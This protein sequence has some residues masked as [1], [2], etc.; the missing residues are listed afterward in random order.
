[1]RLT[2][3]CHDQSQETILTPLRHLTGIVFLSQKKSILKID[4][5]VKEAVSQPR[6]QVDHLSIQ[7]RRVGEYSSTFGLKK[8]PVAPP[9]QQIFL[10]PRFWVVTW[11][12]ASR[13]SVP[14]TKGGREERPWE[15]GWPWHRLGMGVACSYSSAPERVNLGSLE[16]QWN[17]Y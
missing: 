12:A 1:M 5:S 2:W 9:F 10:P 7:N 8:N 4:R 6:S 13:V 15:R 14:T 3:E 11:P 17:L 16:L